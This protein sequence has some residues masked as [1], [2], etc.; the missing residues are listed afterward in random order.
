VDTSRPTFRPALIVTVDAAGDV[1]LIRVREADGYD[2]VRAASVSS[3]D[4]SV[5]ISWIHEWLRQA[6][7]VVVAREPGNPSSR[8]DAD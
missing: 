4:S 2:S 7:E 1:P 5:V 6:V 8:T 3:K